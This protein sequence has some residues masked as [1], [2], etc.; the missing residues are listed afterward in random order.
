MPSTNAERVTLGTTHINTK[1][2]HK[3]MKQLQRA[4]HIPP[5][6]NIAAYLAMLQVSGL[7][8]KSQADAIRA[9]FK[10]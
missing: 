7:V 1:A 5:C 2:I 3:L 8:S 9:Q 10:H 4:Y 6:S